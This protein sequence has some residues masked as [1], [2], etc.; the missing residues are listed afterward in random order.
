MRG[1]VERDEERMNK[2][3]ERERLRGDVE[4]EEREEHGVGGR[5]C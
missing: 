1:K 5:L 2:L 3:R 4:T